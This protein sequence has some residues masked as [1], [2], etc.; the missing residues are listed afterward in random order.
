M[1]Y[2]FIGLCFIFCLL[3]IL[4][5]R[6]EQYTKNVLSSI[7]VYA[8]VICIYRISIGLADID[9]SVSSTPV[10]VLLVIAIA[11]HLVYQF[12]QTDIKWI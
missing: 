11:A 5:N 1:F 9:A 10:T 3:A 2:L 6:D 7:I 12:H 4:N 8:L